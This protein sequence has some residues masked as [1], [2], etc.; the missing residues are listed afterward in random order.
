MNNSDFPAYL[1]SLGLRTM[2]LRDGPTGPKYPI[3]KEYYDTDVPESHK[4]QVGQ[5]VILNHDDAQFPSKRL[6]VIDADS[7]GMADYLADV[8][9]KDVC[10]VTTRKGKHFYGFAHTGVRGARLLKWLP[11]VDWLVGNSYAVCQTDHEDHPRNWNGKPIT[12]FPSE[13]LQELIEQA[14]AWQAYEKLLKIRGKVNSGRHKF[15]LSAGGRLYGQHHFE[16]VLLEEALS[17]IF[18]QYCWRP[19]QGHKDYD[20]DMSGMEKHITDMVKRADEK[21]QQSPRKSVKVFDTTKQ[22]RRIRQNAEATGINPYALLIA[23]CVRASAGVSWKVRLWS[24][25]RKKT[26]QPALYAAVFGPSGASKSIAWETACELI[27]Y[28]DTVHYPYRGEMARR[29]KDDDGKTY[30]DPGA[31]IWNEVSFTPSSGQGIMAWMEGHKDREKEKPK[32]VIPKKS[33]RKR[34]RL[35]SAY[36]YNAIARFDEVDRFTAGKQYTDT[37]STDMK[38]AFLG[39]SLSNH[40]G[41]VDRQR[42]VRGGFYVFGAFFCGVDEHMVAVHDD[43]T[44]LRQRFLFFDARKGEIPIPEY[45]KPK[46]VDLTRWHEKPELSAHC[47]FRTSS[48]RTPGHFRVR[49]PKT[50]ARMERKMIEHKT[51]E[52][53]DEP[54]DFCRDFYV[55]AHTFV[56][57]RKLAFAISL[58]HNRKDMSITKQD[59]DIAIEVMKEARRSSALLTTKSKDM[60]RQTL[61]EV[62]ERSAAAESGRAASQDDRDSA[63]VR[64]YCAKFDRFKGKD[65]A[66][67]AIRNIKV[68]RERGRD[69]CE[70]EFEKGAV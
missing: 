21:W 60:Y 4:S 52:E 7:K 18:L 70:V 37:L 33:N 34:Y 28:P 1:R 32:T 38:S 39:G 40:T 55:G 24:S 6:V 30:P 58:I 10:T 67:Q 17:Y 3:F 9:G 22:M 41:T 62:G 8:L 13:P 27:Q 35:G 23:M 12:D 19:E 15:M 53:T 20:R 25:E 47:N 59:V 44:G 68:G 65:G 5:A 31:N 57:L 43:T 66:W 42:E 56:V 45:V 61:K 63:T 2:P 26:C 50:I 16:G 49:E 64:K 69:W 14:S 48:K 29:Q 36:T 54:P 51:L 11:N 46:S